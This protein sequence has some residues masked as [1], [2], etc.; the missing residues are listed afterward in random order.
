MK[1]QEGLAQVTCEILRSRRKTLALY[2]DAQGRLTARAPLSMPLSQIEAF[3]EEK[4]DWIRRAVTKQQ[5]IAA[6]RREIRLTPQQVVQARREAAKDLR[7]RCQRF[8]PLMGVHYRSI[9]ISGAKTRWGSC[10]STGS[11]SFAY[12]LWFAPQPLRDYVVVHELAHLIEMNHSERFWSQVER[13]LPDYKQR[14]NLLKQFQ[15]QVTIAE[16]AVDENCK[17]I[18]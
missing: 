8:A 14:R 5:A 1:Q 12:R 7:E 17:D 16:G 15:Q 6:Q 18:F 13:V 3:V 11:I 9:R 4:A 10:S 2:V